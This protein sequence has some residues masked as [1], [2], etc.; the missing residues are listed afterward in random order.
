LAFGWV[1][2]GLLMPGGDASAQAAAD[3][4]PHWKQAIERPLRDWD[5]DGK[6]ILGNIGYDICLWDAVTG[7]LLH[8]MAGHRETITK[9]QFGPDGGQALSSSWSGPGDG[10]IMLSKD[11]RTILWD[12][13]NGVRTREFPGQV[14]GE[15]SPDG[16]RI[17]TFCQRPGTGVPDGT[18]SLKDKHTGETIEIG[19]VAEFDAAVWETST[20]RQIAKAALDKYSGPE[21]DALHFSRDGLSFA[22]VESGTLLCHNSG[23]GTLYGAGDGQMLG[24]I[25]SEGVKFGRKGRRFPGGGTLA[26]FDREEARMIDFRTGKDTRTVMHGIDF[27]SLW[28]GAW[29]H[30]GS[31]VVL[32]PRPQQELRV[33][34]MKSKKMT[35]VAKTPAQRARNAIVSPDNT[36]LAIAWEAGARGERK[37]C[38]KSVCMT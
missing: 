14:A 25:D 10:W 37:S 2:L 22:F 24:R 28:G 15:F 30:D 6:R 38:R 36:R 4:A 8:R 12:L 32:I 19:T 9:V 23:G 13:A 21:K 29:T 5:Y 31:K 34:D 3:E 1:V 18:P 26:I 33:L 27:S 16:K 35:T 7:K 17:V 20:G 11:T